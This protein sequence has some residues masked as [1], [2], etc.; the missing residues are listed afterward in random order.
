MNPYR[1]AQPPRRWLPKLSPWIFRMT[2]GIRRRKAVKDCNLTGVAVENADIVRGELDK[3]HGVMITPNHPSHADSYV[4]GTA[5]DTFGSPFYC[6][7]TWHVFDNL[8]RIG[9]WILQKHGL[10]SIDREG[11][12]LEAL[13]IARGILQEKREPLIIFPEGEVYHCNDRVTPFREGAAAIAMFAARK[14]ERPIVAI[15]A[16]IKYSYVDDPSE[17]LVEVMTQ[18]E[19]S[20]HWRPRPE[21]PLQKRIYDLAEALMSLKELEYLDEVRTGTLPDRTAALADHILAVNEQAFDLSASQGTVP[22]R[23]K[24]LRRVTL[25]SIV[26]LEDSDDEQRAAL[27]RLLDEMFLVIQL[28]SYP[29][30]YVAEKPSVERI[31]ET[32]DKLEEDLLEQYSATVRG[33]RRATV[34][35]AEPVPVEYSRD[36]TAI[37]ELTVRLQGD[38]QQMVD[39]M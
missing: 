38:V 23:V 13:K 2:R 7:A 3:G 24:E 28:F 8:G 5:A 31:A 22:E 27:D 21:L 35:F 25:E 9:Q 14:A 4:I 36:R 11:T 39:Q 30:D 6:M 33:E 20:I 10:F 19:S 32:I 34:R 29:G 12:D 16:A 26:E 1:M 15:P 37:G 18:L 17:Q